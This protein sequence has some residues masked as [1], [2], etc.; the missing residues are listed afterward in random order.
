MKASIVDFA[1]LLNKKQRLTLELESDFRNQYDRLHDKPVEVSIKKFAENRTLRANAYLWVLITSIGNALRESK[2]DVYFDML[3]DYG[4]GGAVSVL[5]QYEDKFKKSY[6][7]HE[8]LGE[9]ELNGKTFKHYRF[10]VG[11]SEYN[12]DEF[13]ILLD[14]VIREAKQ[15][16]IETKS[17]EE[18]NSLLKEYENGIH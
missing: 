4:Q 9:S 6:K 16:G 2:E 7:Y 15:L 17:Q 10:W 12:K 13:A 11:S 8:F 18:I 1:L 14:G 3:R 5:E